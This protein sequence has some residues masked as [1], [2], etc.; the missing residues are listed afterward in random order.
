MSAACTLNPCT[1]EPLHRCTAAPCTPAGYSLFTMIVAMI[2]TSAL[3][4][5]LCAVLTHAVLTGRLILPWGGMLERACPSGQRRSG[6]PW[7]P[8]ANNWQPP[9]ARRCSAHWRGAVASR[10]RPSLLTARGPAI[11]PQ[12]RPMRSASFPARRPGLS[13]LGAFFARVLPG[14][15]YRRAGTVESDHRGD[16]T[17]AQ[18]QRREAPTQAGPSSCSY[19]PSA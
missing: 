18:P 16:W 17:W 6:P 1:P 14:S 8:R 13:H 3:T 2:A 19:G 11:H 7:P 5:T 4:S 12:G 9:L 15:D 10:C